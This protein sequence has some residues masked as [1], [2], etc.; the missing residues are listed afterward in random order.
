M[1]IAL[2]GCANSGKTTLVQAFLRKWPMYT[3]PTKTYR[4]VIRENNLGHSSKTNEETQ[5]AILDFMLLEQNN[6]SEKSYVIYDRCPWDNLAYTLQGNED[7]LIWEYGPIHTLHVF[8]VNVDYV[9]YP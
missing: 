9:E 3:T 7:N 8:L 2:A 4:D 6:Y 5:L 1:R